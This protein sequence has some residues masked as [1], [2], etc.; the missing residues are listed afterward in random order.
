MLPRPWRVLALALDMHT[1][2]R[3]ESLSIARP[4]APLSESLCPPSVTQDGLPRPGPRQSR[5][6]SAP[7]AQ[8]LGPSVN[9]G[10][11]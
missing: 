4:K 11:T 2:G 9:L 1:H 8:Q 6:Q 3:G 5:R 7:S 10:I